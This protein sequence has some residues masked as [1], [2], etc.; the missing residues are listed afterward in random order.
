M[1]EARVHSKRDTCEARDNLK[2]AFVAEFRRDYIGAIGDLIRDILLL[3][4]GCSC[5]STMSRKVTL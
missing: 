2:S 3:L 1:G 4:T 5:A